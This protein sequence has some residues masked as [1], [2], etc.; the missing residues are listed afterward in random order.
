[1]SFPHTITPH[2][3]PPKKKTKKQKNQKTATTTTT[4][5]LQ[6]QGQL[7]GLFPSMSDAKS[8]MDNQK[9]NVANFFNRW[10]NYVDN[11]RGAL[12]LIYSE[13]FLLTIVVC[14]FYSACWLCHRKIVYNFHNIKLPVA[15]VLDIFSKPM[16]FFVPY[17]YDNHKQVTPSNSC[18]RLVSISHATKL[19]CVNQPLKTKLTKHVFSPGKV[20]STE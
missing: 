6:I 15:R 17:N 20:Q 9:I 14:D 11:F 2:P 4:P 18:P 1:M 12:R 8:G 19:Y 5:L 7:Q 10:N 13:R 3:P 16:T